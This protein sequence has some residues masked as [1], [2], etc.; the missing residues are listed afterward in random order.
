MRFMTGPRG[1]HVAANPGHGGF[2]ARTIPCRSVNSTPPPPAGQ[3]MRNV[4]CMHPCFGE[5]DLVGWLVLLWGGRD[6]GTEFK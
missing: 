6:N 5:W 4:A 3:G 2:A 1:D